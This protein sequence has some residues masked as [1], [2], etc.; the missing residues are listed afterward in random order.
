MKWHPEAKEEY[1]SAAFLID[2]D[3]PGYGDRFVKAVRSKLKLVQH[4][5]RLG[6]RITDVDGEVRR[7]I[8]D[9]FSYKLIIGIVDDEPW[10]VAVAH[11]RRS[12][13]Y[14]HHRLQ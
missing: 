11:F 2:E 6:T 13:D 9:R 5:P 12:P 1:E 8:V 4:F 3:R 10:V 14:W 7:V